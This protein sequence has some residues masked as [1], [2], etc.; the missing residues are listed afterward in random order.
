MGKNPS[1]TSQTWISPLLKH[2]LHSKLNLS[3][4]S[5]ISTRATCGDDSSKIGRI[6]CSVRLCKIR[7]I[8]NVECLRSELKIDAFLDG[9]VLCQRQID[10]REPW[11][12]NDVSASI[13][14]GARLAERATIGVARV[15]LK[16]SIFV[17]EEVR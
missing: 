1:L 13:P 17:E 16:K 11:A 12:F 15:A 8:Q 14:E 10:V 4:R 3:R 2:Q 9:R 7:V 5:E 6:H